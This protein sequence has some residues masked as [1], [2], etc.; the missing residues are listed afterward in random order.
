MSVKSSHEIKAD[1]VNALIQSLMDL[2]SKRTLAMTGTY[3]NS[4]EVKSRRLSN[5]GTTSRLT[6]INNKKQN[7]K[8]NSEIYNDDLGY[9]FNSC[10]IINDIPKLKSSAKNIDVFSDGFVEPNDNITN[11]KLWID[12]YKGASGTDS[13]SKT[14]CRGACVG[15][16][17][18]SCYTTCVSGCKEGNEG[19]AGSSTG[20]SSSATS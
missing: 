10:L 11:L 19:N 6:Q 17:A 9:I 14:G 13:K 16:C 7:I 18:G 8:A 5:T 3:E 4:T 12:N 20:G 15:I 1:E 2:Y